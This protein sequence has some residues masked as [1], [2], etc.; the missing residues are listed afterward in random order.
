MFGA[1]SSNYNDYTQKFWLYN[2][3]SIAKFIQIDGR[4]IA[5]GTQQDSI[6][7]TRL[8]DDPNYNWGTIYITEDAEFSKFGCG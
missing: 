7:F 5:E 4:I 2:G 3:D 1:Q 6:V 8:Q